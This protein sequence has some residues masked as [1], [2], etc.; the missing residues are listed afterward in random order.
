MIPV[1]T[2]PGIRGGGMAE[3][4]RG[5]ELKCDIFDIF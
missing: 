4:R 5:G 1:Q 2:V 3:S